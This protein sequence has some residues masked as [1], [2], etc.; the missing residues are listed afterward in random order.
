MT[1]G[2]IN[3]SGLW[4]V[5]VRAFD[6]CYRSGDEW[7]AVSLLLHR[8][9][10]VTH[11]EN[12]YTITVQPTGK[13]FQFVYIHRM[14]PS[15]VLRFVMPDGKE[16]ERWDESAQSP[17]RVKNEVPPRTRIIGPNGEIIRK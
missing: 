5:P 17:D 8:V 7:I 2:F 14:N 1:L 4:T 11:Q 9:T 10:Q 3:A 12:T 13:G 16:L 6:N 15:A